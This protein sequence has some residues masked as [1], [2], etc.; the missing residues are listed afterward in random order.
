M[1]FWGEGAAL[2]LVAAAFAACGAALSTLCGPIDRPNARSN[3]R[4]P[5]PRAGGLSLLLGAGAAALALA[6]GL[7]PE[8]RGA[9]GADAAR[10]AP[11]LAA[12]GAFA[13]LGLLDD[14]SVIGLRRKFFGTIILAA[15]A[16]WAAGPAPVLDGGAFVL[17][18]PWGVAFA[19]AALFVFVAVNAVNFMDGSDGMMAANLF[20]AGAALSLFGLACGAPVAAVCGLMLAGGCAGF[21][22]F[23]APRARVFSGDAGAFFGAALFACGALDL[24]RNGAAGAIWIVP[25]L[26]APFLGDVFA[27]L[28]ARARRGAKLTEGHSEHVYQLLIARGWSHPRVAL[29]YLAM[30]VACVA[31]AA[32]ALAAGPG[33]AALA[34]AVVAPGGLALALYARK[35][36]N[37]RDARA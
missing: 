29:L 16:A 3:H 18:L 17:T 2:A 7:A 8:L 21:A 9:L 30:S 36:L 10:L 37:L 34:L 19:G 32:A 1:D 33:W 15:L 13:L 20:A 22:L 12:C 11:I 24:A 5:R 28:I 14:L 26:L 6:F 4:T 27:T 31:I 23:N 25:L 35:R